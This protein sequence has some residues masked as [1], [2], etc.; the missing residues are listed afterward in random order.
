MRYQ[1]FSVSLFMRQQ[2]TPIPLLS[3]SMVRQCSVEVWV[4]FET[5]PDPARKGGDGQDTPEI[6]ATEAECVALL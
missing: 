6:S 4:A 2:K 3:V 1:D 5:A